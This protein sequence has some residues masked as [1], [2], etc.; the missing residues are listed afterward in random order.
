M[1]Q[2]EKMKVLQDLVHIDSVNG[3]EKT[4]AEYV[5]D[6]LKQHDIESKIIPLSDDDT[7]ANLVAEI[8]SGKPVLAV[9]GHMDTV[10]V[11]KDAWDSDPFELTDKDGKLYGRGATDMKSGLAALAI[12]MIELKEANVELN[13]TI[14]LLA[15]AGEEV[16]MQGSEEL[17]KQ[18][19]MDDVDTLLIAEPSG[20]LYS[21]SS[22]GEL[23]ITFT[24]EGKAAHSSMPKMGINAIQQFIDFWS[25]LKQ[26][27]DDYNKTAE[28]KVLGHA[29]YNV[30][31]IKG[32]TQANT[33][34]D[35]LEALLNVRTVPEFDNDKVLEIIDQTIA[36]FN[37]Q[38]EGKISDEVGM[39]VI[40][41]DGN[42]DAKIIDLIKQITKKDLGKDIPMIG[43]PGGTDASKFLKQHPTGFNSVTFGPGDPTLAHQT[44]EYVEKDMYL[45]FI[46]MYVE[47]F[48]A[49]FK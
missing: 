47:L 3:N 23:N 10:D 36:D 28:N 33:I 25:E 24:S 44:N 1:D 45:K 2:N 29:V 8:G 27:L 9:S 22:K 30:D 19:Y 32:G 15:T 48:Q 35:K 13:G 12:A 39:Q 49:F 11:D 41:I 37:K 20:Y 46:D 40:A 17:E 38:A 43:V 16:G 5:Q 42:P 14:R 7:R 31:V 18:G 21:Y 34:P 26:N 4:V 6:L